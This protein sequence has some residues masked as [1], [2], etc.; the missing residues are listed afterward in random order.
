MSAVARNS[1]TN[2]KTNRIMIKWRLEWVQVS[3]VWCSV[4]SVGS[5]NGEKHKQN[6]R[7]KLTSQGRGPME[8][9]LL[10]E[11]EA[12]LRIELV[13]QGIG[14]CRVRMFKERVT[15]VVSQKQTQITRFGSSLLMQQRARRTSRDGH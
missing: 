4:T 6:R 2:H 11:H 10:K 14:T 5:R 8:L 7:M 13:S 1:E 12:E 9:R 15:T 3:R